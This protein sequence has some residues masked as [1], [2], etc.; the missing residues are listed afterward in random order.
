LAP[1]GGLAVGSPAG[2]LTPLRGL[3]RS[4]TP[5]SERQGNRAQLRFDGPLPRCPSVARL[6]SLAADEATLLERIARVTIEMS[7]WNEY[8]A[9]HALPPVLRRVMLPP[10]RSRQTLNDLHSLLVEEL[11]L[12]VEARET[13]IVLL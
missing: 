5:R 2:C 4:H 3:S 7:A 8:E 10:E 12:V 6:T 1:P 13:L 11:G 9:N